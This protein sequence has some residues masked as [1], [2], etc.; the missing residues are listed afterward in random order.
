[1]DTIK[2]KQATFRISALLLISFLL[3]MPYAFLF[4]STW[5]TNAE[6]H[7]VV[8]TCATLIAFFIGILALVNYYS[9]K[10]GTILFIGTGFL[11][12]A[13]LDGFHAIVTSSFF[14]PF[15]PSDNS[16][17]I[18]WSWFASRSFLSIYLFLSLLAWRK[19]KTSII[20]NTIS[21]KNVYV[22]AIT[23]TLLS[24]LFFAFVPLPPGY[25]SYLIFKRPEE[26]IPALFFLLAIIG[27]LYKGEWKNNAFEYFIILSLI[28]GFIGQ[29]ALYAV[30]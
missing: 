8:E 17:L 28:I 2:S 13:F 5:D 12:T 18:P 22:T 3:M 4:N 20:Y 15:M 9:K 29:A 27:Y 10:E 26:F 19:E 14:V 30:I 25:F 24:F 21:E 11:G 23:F 16:F 6:I 1:M 7:T